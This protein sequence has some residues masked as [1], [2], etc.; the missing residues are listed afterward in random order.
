MHVSSGTSHS[1]Q[2]HPH[3]Q[4]LTKRPAV[5]QWNNNP[6]TSKKLFTNFQYK[7]MQVASKLQLVI[8]KVERWGSPIHK[9]RNLY[10]AIP[11]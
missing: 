8:E 5:S 6:I 2:F 9:A 3:S 1:N 10:K 4:S 11:I 7:Q